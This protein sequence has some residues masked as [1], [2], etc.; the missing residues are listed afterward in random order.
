MSRD[1][2]LPELQDV[3]RRL[4]ANQRAVERLDYWRLVAYYAVDA[5]ML[6]CLLTSGVVAVYK[7]C[8]GEPWP[9]SWAAFG[10]AC[11]AYREAAKANRRRPGA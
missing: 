2:H 1:V 8:L 3:A 5:L 6:A 7:V 9:V 10:I 4:A 11:E